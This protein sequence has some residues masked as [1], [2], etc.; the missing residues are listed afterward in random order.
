MNIITFFIVMAVLLNHGFA[1]F[2]LQS[3]N[4]ATQ[5]SISK[6][7]LS[8]H[9][10][11][12]TAGMI[13]LGVM[14]WIL[15]GNPFYGLG[16]LLG[17]GTMHWVTDYYTSKWTSKLYANQQFYTPNKYVKFVNF[18]SFFSVIE[19]DQCIHYACLFG[20]LTFLI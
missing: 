12:Y 19:M 16:W 6:Y 4:M 13:P 5:K 10:L 8:V 20:S 14:V 18:P 7:W 1:D 3:K 2:L 17:N 9:V 11:A 15:S